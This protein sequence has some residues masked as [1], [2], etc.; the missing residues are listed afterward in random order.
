[1]TET[2]L[3]H[4]APPPL[5]PYPLS[6]SPPSPPR[7]TPR[8]AA[9]FFLLCVMRAALANYCL[10]LLSASGSVR[11]GLVSAS[12]TSNALLLH[13]RAQAVRGLNHE[14]S[15]HESGLASLAR[16]HARALCSNEMVARVIV[17]HAPALG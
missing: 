15:R 14:A 3:T 11:D 1:M 10:A 13:T 17:K 12:A 2:E 16:A 5:P 4:L 6:V 9:S 7:R 8:L